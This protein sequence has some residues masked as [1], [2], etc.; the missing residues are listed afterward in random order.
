MRR[1]ILAMVAL[2]GAA[3]AAH[4]QSGFLQLKYERVEA[5]AR[6]LRTATTFYDTTFTLSYWTQSYQLNQTRIF[7]PQLNFAWQLGFQ[8]RQTVDR[9]DRVQIPYGNARLTLPTAG[10]YASVRPSTT[11]QSLSTS[12]AA[13]GSL[14]SVRTELVRY[15]ATQSVV[16]AYVAPAK[17]PRLDF[18]WIGDQRGAATGARKNFSDRRDLRL[19][20]TLG[21][22]SWRAS[23]GDLASGKDAFRTTPYQRSYGAG[24][25]LAV[26]PRT[27]MLLNFDY[28]FSRYDRGLPGTTKS[29]TR[30]HRASVNGNWTQRPDLSW[31][32]FS[33]Y[34][35][36]TV[37]TFESRL[38]EGAEGQLYLLYRPRPV[39]RMQ[40]GTQ[41]RKVFRGLESG[42]EQ[43]ALADATFEGRVRQGW[44]STVNLSESGVWNTLRSPYSVTTLRANTRAKVREGVDVTLDG[45]ASANSDST[46]AARTVSQ[47]SAGVL[48]VPL[49][50]VNLTL[51]SG[52]Y[53][54]GRTFSDPNNTSRT[55]QLDLR[56][57][58]LQNVEFF[59]SLRS[60]ATG[61]TID[62]SSSTRT[63]YVRWSPSTLLQ[64]TLDYSKNDYDVSSSPAGAYSR[65]KREIVTTRGT[66][67][68]DRAKQVTGTASIINARQADESHAYDASFTWRFGR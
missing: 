23:Y 61:P 60:Q 5:Q 48:L 22:A 20:Q 42:V 4:A 66:W 21:Q 11:T 52:F 27:A 25:A 18:S 58:P 63:A 14:D 39:F 1:A 2:S 56:W 50:T 54:V 38:S 53:R 35:R 15:R 37:R 12:L 59:G 45:Q 55:G 17:L 40:A 36:S 41:V 49:R 28:D 9:T 30:S 13:S 62:V 68:I 47:G 33:W 24:A 34:Q 6:L 46:F 51:R 31:N 57:T 8:D 10:F 67:S 65:Q 3:T 7:N 32:L 26:T 44:T 43:I 29:G 64:L 16:S 19:T